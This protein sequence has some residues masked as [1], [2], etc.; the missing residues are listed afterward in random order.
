MPLRILITFLATLLSVSG[1]AHA[2]PRPGDVF[3]EYNMATTM[4]R[5]GE[6]PEWGGSNW[7][8]NLILATNR[9]PEG[10]PYEVDLEGATRAEV[11]VGYDQCHSG[12]TGLAIAFNDNEYLRLPV[13][14]TVPEP[15][16][17]YMQWPYPTVQVPMA[18]L[19]GG[20]NQI[21]FRIDPPPRLPKEGGW[22]QNIV[23]SVV[24]RIY[25]GKDKPHV[26]GTVTGVVEDGEIGLSADLGVQITA[27]AEQV[28]RV[29]YVGQYLDFDHDSDGVFREWQYRYQ[30]FEEPGLYGH[31]GTSATAPFGVTWDTRWIPDQVEPMHIA[32]RVV[33]QDGMV[34]MT[35]EI[36]RIRLVR[37]GYSVEMCQPFNVPQGWV[38]RK[39]RMGQKFEVR[40]DLSKAKSARV[41]FRSWGGNDD[42]GGWVNQ[43]PFERF[44]GPWFEIPVAAIKSGVNTIETDKGGHHG[45]EI[46][47]P[48]AV[49]FVQYDLR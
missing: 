29:E 13:S 24:L 8:K 17:G 35:P 28:A 3:R 30:A 40:G 22:Q 16:A 41:M 14:D 38:T 4:W 21:K 15:V 6:R 23:Y 39:G 45:M 46:V 25:Y 34:Y 31:I 44:K 33:T 9:S 7:G 2:H 12:T 42:K 43:T 11:V 27:G 26:Q 36:R 5:V 49:V 18:H 20:Q 32:A 37:V 10:K 48:G 47:W 1:I 19:K